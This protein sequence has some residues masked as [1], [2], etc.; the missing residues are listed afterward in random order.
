MILFFVSKVQNRNFPNLELSFLVLFSPLYSF[1]CDVN[2]ILKTKLSTLHHITAKEPKKTAL[3]NS[4]CCSAFG[5]SRF[6]RSLHFLL[7]AT[8]I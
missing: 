1:R 7:R 5:A 6:L 4:G 8:Q 3:A 2:M